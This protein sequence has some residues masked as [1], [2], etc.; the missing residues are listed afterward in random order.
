MYTDREYRISRGHSAYI[1]VLDI[2]DSRDQRCNRCVYL[3]I[4]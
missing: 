1:S 4:I 2:A 3:Y